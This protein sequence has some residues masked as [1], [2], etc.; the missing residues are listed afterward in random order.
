[1]R[2]G[3]TQPALPIGHSQEAVLPPAIGAAARVVVRQ[4]IPAAPVGR[5]VFADRAPLPLGEIRTPALPVL[6]SARV[7]L[8]TEHLG[9]L[10][11]PR[12]SRRHALLP[13]PGPTRSAAGRFAPL[14][15]TGPVAG[16]PFIAAASCAATLPFVAALPLVAGFPGAAAST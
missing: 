1:E 14:S 4:V 13:L 15:A 2:Q 9:I 3:E 5:V 16:L 6:P 10:L 7:L 8:E 12:S 11:E